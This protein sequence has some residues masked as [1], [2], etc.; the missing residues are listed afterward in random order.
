MV[1]SVH[2][3][4]TQASVILYLAVQEC[5]GGVRF[6]QGHIHN[7]KNPQAPVIKLMFVN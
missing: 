5:T 3:S 6:S 7:H 2:H 4:D 1:C